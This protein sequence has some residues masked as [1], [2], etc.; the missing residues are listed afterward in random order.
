MT[1]IRWIT[2][3]VFVGVIALGV[4]LAVNLGGDP[5]VQTNPTQ[6]KPAPEFTLTTFDGKRVDLTALRGHVVLV[7][8]VVA[9]AF[10]RPQHENREARAIRLEEH[11]ACPVCTGE[12]IAHS[13]S[14]QA[15]TMRRDVEARIT[16]GESDSQILGY[17]ARSFP[18]QQLNP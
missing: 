10:L 4:L 17:Y 8:V 1:R 18:N 9:V 12:D 6:G 15:I 2:T 14:E 7:A 11:I 16:R 5:T 3:V 13:N